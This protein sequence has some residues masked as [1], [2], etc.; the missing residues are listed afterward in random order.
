MTPYMSIIVFGFIACV[1]II[2]GS[3]GLLADLYVFGSM[4]SFTA[5][6]VSVIVLRIR[7]PDLER[8]WRPPFNVRV[9]GKLCRSR[10]SSAPWGPSVS[11][12]SSSRSGRGRLIGFAWFGIG[13]VMYVVYRKAKGY[14][15]GGLSPR[16]DDRRR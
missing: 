3:T 9:N 10:R 8:P 2:P 15:L 11:G 13:L 1:L 4:I 14:S 16:S 6:H 7:E 12:W 5:A